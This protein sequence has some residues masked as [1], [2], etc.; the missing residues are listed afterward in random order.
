MSK[1]VAGFEERL[2]AVQNIITDIE[3][4]QLP[5][6]ESVSK[7]EEGM[8][9]LIGLNHELEDVRQR[10]TVIRTSAEGKIIEENSVEKT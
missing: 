10:L 8:K 3:E 5:L 9:L 7:Y 1:N 2:L 6:E 4:K